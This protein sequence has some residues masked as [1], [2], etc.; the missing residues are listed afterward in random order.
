MGCGSM[1]CPSGGVRKSHA[2]GL[3]S[4]GYARVGGSRG[5]QLSF[6]CDKARG[7]IASDLDHG[8]T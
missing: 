5:L 7:E 6:A 1:F 4:V 3:I 8:V 2:R